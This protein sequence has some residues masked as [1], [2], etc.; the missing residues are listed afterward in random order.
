MGMHEKGFTET[1]RQ[2]C[3]S[4][5]PYS[6][7]AFH[8]IR[9]ALEFTTKSLE[10]PA[11]GPDRHVTGRE[12]TEGIRRFALQEYGPM[13][14]TVFKEWG[15]SNTEDFGRIVFLLVESGKLGKTED[16]RI[17]DFTN[18]YDFDTAFKLPFLPDR[19]ASAPAAAGKTPYRKR[20]TG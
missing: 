6:P 7:Q 18:G 20:K 17:E 8:F 16:D 11:E 4:G 10:R 9:A 3:S 12:L 14:S 15:V 2:I 1:V 19:A 5:C 13:A